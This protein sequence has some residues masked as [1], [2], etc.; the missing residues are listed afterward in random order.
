MPKRKT[1]TESAPCS[2]PVEALYSRDP[3]PQY[4]DAPEEIE[5]MARELCSF[6]GH[7]PDA[8]VFPGIP[9]TIRTHSDRA[10]IIPEERLLLRAW[11]LYQ[12]HALAARHL[13]TMGLLG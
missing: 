12:P 5:R 8:L 9:E 3:V 6:H 4:I 10:F 7:N 1:S 13:K 11:Q 2:N